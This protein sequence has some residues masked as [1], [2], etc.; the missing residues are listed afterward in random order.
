MSLTDYHTKYYAHELTR[1]YPSNDSQKLASVLNDAKVDLNPHQVEAALFAFKS[2]LSKGAI[3]ADEVGLGKTIEAGLVIAQKWSEGK[4]RILII[5]PSSLRNQWLQELQ[6]K[7][8]IPSI[9]LEAKNFKEFR[10]SGIRNPFEQPT[11]VICSINFAANRDDDVML[12]P[13]DLVVIDEAHRLRN[14]YKPGNKM[15]KALKNALKE[16]PKLLLTATPLQNSL[17]EL[18]G[19]VSII[20]EHTFGDAKS[21]KSQYCRSADN[22]I[23]TE[24]K[25]RL[26]PVCHRTLRKH[27][28]EYIKYTNR[29]PVTQEFVPT[30]A[31]EILYDKVSEYLRRPNLQAL[32]SQGLMILIM[33]KLLASSTFA[34]A[35][36][37]NT[38]IRKLE[39]KIKK[40][41]AFISLKEEIAEDYESFSEM[42][43]EWDEVLE[44]E[45]N[46]LTEENYI[47]IQKE[48]LD[49]KEYSNLAISISENARGSALLTALQTGF[50]KAREIGAAEKVIIF[51]ESRRTQE[52]LIKLLSRHG[53][54]GIL[55]FN[56]TN[57]DSESKAI[58]KNWF[59]KNEGTDRIT[60]SKSA[61]MR[62]ALVDYFRYSARI[63]IATEAA[64]EGVNLQF[65]SMVVNYDL[66]WNPQRIEQ[67]IGRCHRYGQQHDVV[68]INFLNIKNAA[69]LR[70][71]E[72]L[73]DKFSLFSGVFGAS[74]DVLGAIES[75]V[76]IEKR[77]VEIYQ[78][79]R[80]PAEIE[81]EF[82]RLSADVD[83]KISQ[84]MDDTR[85]KLLENFDAEVH[86][87]LRVNLR[88][89]KEYISKYETL[90]WDLTRHELRG[91]ANF[92]HKSLKFT[93]LNPIPGLEEIM[94]GLYHL[95]RNVQE[96]H[97]Y[98]VGHSLAQHLIRKAASR[99]L[100]CSQ[101]QIHYTNQGQ[102]AAALEPLVG[103]KGI[104]ASIKLK[105]EGKD[106]EDHIL[107]CGLT[108]DGTVLH[109]DQASRMMRYP[110]KVLKEEY[111][112]W[113]IRIQDQLH[114]RKS[115]IMQGLI[116]RKSNLF[117]EEMEKLDKWA[118]DK[119]TSLKV[120]LKDLDEE[121]KAIKKEIKTTKNLQTKINL[122]RQ[123]KTLETKRN[124]AWKKYDDEI[125]EIDKQ[126]DSLLDEVEARLG[127]KAIEERL[128]L[129]KWQL[130]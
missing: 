51:T 91:K 113:P 95:G 8:Y 64:A 130:I 116:E 105:I 75:G 58:Y 42:E 121:I 124:I 9:I 25:N 24:L 97:R 52:Y 11:L 13:W 59:K 73:K 34:I 110:A 49:L 27:V 128:F 37:L 94:P 112:E 72:L 44:D 47:A 48:I 74:D 41:N 126:K 23:I 88:D 99:E 6:E 15:G 96:A 56:G 21:F 16:V 14:V 102:K 125:Q 117:D 76:E 119:R 85:K 67:R 101:L 92:D 108:E 7:F 46:N 20:D 39:A 38:L 55:L 81:A 61:D 63:M 22:E 18:Y 45:A 122:Q 40:T 104:L 129:I 68:V 32:P 86:D 103:K 35:G 83:G 80:T 89:S 31:E 87:R 60:G 71:Y 77:I 100:P 19:L 65:C 111:L 84:A 3:L 90:L 66:P 36:A 28:L 30:D 43:D 69:D 1:R 2:P 54:E 107:F 79:C 12:V 33:R 115:E 57:A 62:T 123:V 17:L 53:Y 98:R 29:I 118:E 114:A 93:L 82:A 106:A 120:N 127:Q 70:V 50:A 109:E 10:R 78:N 26:K 5:T 4:R